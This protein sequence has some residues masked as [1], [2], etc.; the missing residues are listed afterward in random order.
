M[1]TL[2]FD[3]AVSGEIVRESV[4]QV[5]PI[6]LP[7]VTRNKSEYPAKNQYFPSKATQSEKTTILK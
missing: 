2:H 7:K 4:A 5:Q 3:Q 1:E 6:I